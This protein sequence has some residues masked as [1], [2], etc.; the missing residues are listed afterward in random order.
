MFG[1]LWSHLYKLVQLEPSLTKGV[2]IPQ[3]DNVQN[4]LNS[5]MHTPSLN[6]TKFYSAL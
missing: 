4:T 3:G 6:F 1:S 5:S 2:D